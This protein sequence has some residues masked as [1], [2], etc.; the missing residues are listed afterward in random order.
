MKPSWKWYR[1]SLLLAALYLPAQ[2]GPAQSTGDALELI[3]TRA[4]ESIEAEIT[5]IQNQKAAAEARRAYVESK[6]TVLTSNLEKQEAEVEVAEKRM[7]LAEAQD[8]ETDVAEVGNEVQAA[9]WKLETLELEQSLLEAETE[10]AEA[11]IDF[12]SGAV[13]ALTLESEL[14]GKRAEREKASQSAEKKDILPQLDRALFQAEGEVLE[15]FRE[16]ADLRAEFAQREAQV[17]GRQMELHDLHGT[18]KG[19][20]E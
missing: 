19:L 11:E 7:E 1:A 14:A 13:K 3:P 20:K 6:R 9:R 8:K 18:M 4:T 15:A 16:R 17:V 12:L 5:A 2:S 10:L